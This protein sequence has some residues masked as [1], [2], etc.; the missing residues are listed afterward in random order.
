LLHNHP[1]AP[2][3]TQPGPDKKPYVTKILN[4]TVSPEG[5]AMS[6]AKTVETVKNRGAAK[7][8]AIARAT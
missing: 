7:R 4:L 8:T 2:K 1:I 6:V 5:G 3:E